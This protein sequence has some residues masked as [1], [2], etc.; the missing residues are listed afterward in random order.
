MTIIELKR[1]G[2]CEDSRQARASIDTHQGS[3]ALRMKLMREIEGKG[4]GDT[5]RREA[6]EAG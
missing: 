3:F 6:Q 1:I 4:G 2:W 5:K